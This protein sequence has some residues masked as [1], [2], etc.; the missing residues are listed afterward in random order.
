M[1]STWF[2]NTSQMVYYRKTI[3]CLYCHNDMPMVRLTKNDC[4][5]EVCE[6]IFCSKEP[7]MTIYNNEPKD[8]E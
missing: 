7:L 6:I 4:L 1:G 5:C 3:T 8:E 2:N